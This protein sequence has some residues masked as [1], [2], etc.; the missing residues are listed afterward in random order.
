MAMKEFSLSDKHSRILSEIMKERERQAGPMAR[1]SPRATLLRGM[2]S[3]EVAG[4]SES[5]KY[6]LREELTQ[7]AAACV[8]YLE[9][10]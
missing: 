7:V 3:R 10:L 6:K 9:E 5:A 8:A 1:L 4:A 2:V